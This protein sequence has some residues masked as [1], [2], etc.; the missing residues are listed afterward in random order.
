MPQ[1]TESIS[2]D[3]NPRASEAAVMYRRKDQDMDDASSAIIYPCFVYHVS[4]TRYDQ[5]PHPPP[6]HNIAKEEMTN[7]QAAYYLAHAMPGRFVAGDDTGLEALLGS[8]SL[9]S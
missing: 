8:M 1:R 4:V 9:E 2:I 6:R 7:R 3:E 5:H